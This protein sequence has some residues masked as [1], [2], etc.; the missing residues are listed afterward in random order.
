MLNYTMQIPNT[1]DQLTPHNLIIPKPQTTKQKLITATIITATAITLQYTLG[2]ITTPPPDTQIPHTAWLIILAAASLLT[3]KTTFVPAYDPQIHHVIQNITYAIALTAIDQYHHTTQW[4][5]NP[6]NTLPQI[7]TE[8]H[9][10]PL[11]IIAAY[12]YILTISR[13]AKQQTGN[14][15]TAIPIAI[16]TYFLT[17]TNYPPIIPIGINAAA[18]IASAHYGTPTVI[19]ERQPPGIQIDDQTPIHT[20]KKQP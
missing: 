5:L 19:Y 6:T 14:D 4:T 16:T 1:K 12:V 2:N 7:L 11:L 18:L 20:W 8:P 13:I 9:Q 3:N 15:I 17:T 10:H